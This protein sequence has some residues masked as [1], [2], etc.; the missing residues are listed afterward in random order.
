MYRRIA[1][2]ADALVRHFRNAIWMHVHRFDHVIAFQFTQGRGQANARHCMHGCSCRPNG[3]RGLAAVH[4]DTRDV[5]A[6]VPVILAG[7][8][9]GVIA[10]S[11]I[12]TRAHPFPAI[13]GT[14]ALPA[15]DVGQ[16]VFDGH[17]LA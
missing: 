17:A 14:R 6:R 7:D 16:T 13:A 2:A 11:A 9:F 1:L 3:A 10:H 12:G 8:D 4:I 15:A 5:A